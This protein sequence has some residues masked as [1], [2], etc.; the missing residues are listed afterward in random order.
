[1]IQTQG[2]KRPLFF[3]HSIGGGVLY[4][5]DLAKVL[6]DDQPFY[7]LQA[8]GLEDDRT[9]VKTTP[10]LAALY[11]E[12]M[13]KVQP[14]GPYMIGG[15]SYGGVVAFEIAVQLQ[16][17]GAE[18]ALLAMLDSRVPIP[19]DEGADEVYYALDHLENLA[20]FH[21]RPMPIKQ[22]QVVGMETEAALRL[23][24]QEGVNG[25]L[26]S[27]ESGFEAFRRTIDVMHAN[28][29]AFHT[30][31]PTP[32]AGN[33]TMLKAIERPEEEAFVPT[34]GWDQFIGGEIE[35]RLVP[36][37]HFTMVKHPYV[38]DVGEQLK[39]CLATVNLA[40]K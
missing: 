40:R 26:L 25:Q 35:V 6:G 4:Y 23:I 33:L 38:Q 32:Y 3:V 11:I 10:E 34:N 22:E 37:N 12:E 30:Y 7:G 1:G 16:K 9:T 5:S 15:W 39:D 19:E 14:E 20:I 28:K 24:F 8:P 29:K 21:E 2:T 17:Q 36:G 13:R 18:V 31:E 27:L